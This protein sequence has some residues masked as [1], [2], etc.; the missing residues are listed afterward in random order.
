MFQLQV[1]YYTTT[2]HMDKIGGLYWVKINVIMTIALLVVFNVLRKLYAWK[3]TVLQILYR[4]RPSGP[5]S[6]QYL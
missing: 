6:I 4:I 3:M 1:H 5:H 2:F